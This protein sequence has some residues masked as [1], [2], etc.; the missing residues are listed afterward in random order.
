MR[1]KSR[2]LACHAS[3]RDWLRRQHGY[4]RYLDVMRKAAREE[5]KPFGFQAAEGF[6]QHRGEGYPQDNILQKLLGP[7]CVDV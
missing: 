2:M 7:L 5:G 4:D 1:T 6:I 3:Q